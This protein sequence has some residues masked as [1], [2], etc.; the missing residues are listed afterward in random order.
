LDASALVGIDAGTAGASSTAV[1]QSAMESAGVAAG[2][3]GAA[4][5]LAESSA[6]QGG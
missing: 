5:A 1:A 4:A 2:V 3:S 6:A